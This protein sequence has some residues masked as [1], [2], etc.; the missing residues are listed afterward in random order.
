L[1]FN[2]DEVETDLVVWL[3][4]EMA[5]KLGEFTKHVADLHH[6]DV[7]DCDCTDEEI[8]GEEEVK[9]EGKAVRAPEE[10]SR[11]AGERQDPSS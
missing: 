8:Y 11:G 2:S 5:K 3:K 6:W 7:D 4:D 1:S 10:G 9:L